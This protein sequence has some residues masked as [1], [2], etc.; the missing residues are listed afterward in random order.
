MAQYTEGDHVLERRVYAFSRR[1]PSRGVVGGKHDMG[2]MTVTAKKETKKGVIFEVLQ[3]HS[4]F[5]YY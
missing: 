5:S 3:H 2:E 1:D 4:T